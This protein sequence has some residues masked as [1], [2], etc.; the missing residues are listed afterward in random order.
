MRYRELKPKPKLID[1]FKVVKDSSSITEAK[2][3]IFSLTYNLERNFTPAEQA[4]LEPLRDALITELDLDDEEQ[5]AF[6]YWGNLIRRQ[7]KSRY[8]TYVD[9]EVILPDIKTALQAKLQQLKN[10]KDISFL[11]GITLVKRACDE[12]EEVLNG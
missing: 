5:K 4:V 8:K 12:L 6:I 2:R 11:S 10:N 1:L 3:S 9:T 7:L